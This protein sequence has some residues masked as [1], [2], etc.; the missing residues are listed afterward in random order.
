MKRK[1]VIL[2]DK[3]Q[4]SPNA[5]YLKFSFSNPQM[6]LGLATGKHIGIFAPMI[7]GKVHGKWNNGP[8]SEAGKSE[9][10][11]KF[12]PISCDEMDIGYFALVVKIYRPSPKFPDGG[13]MS[14]YLE[15]LRV[16]SSIEVA[17]PFGNH[18]YIGRGRLADNGNELIFKDCAMIAGGSG[19]TP[20]L[21]IV[22]AMLRDPSD[23]TRISLLYANST[24]DDILMRDHLDTL[25][26]TYPTRFRVWYTVSQDPK[27]SSKHYSFADWRYSTGR[28]TKQMMREHLPPPSSNNSIAIHCGPKAMMENVNRLLGELGYS[29]RRI[30]EY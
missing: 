4:I 14:R 19:I 13:R 9:I 1:R 5:Y 21:Q 8:D 30:V 10:T 23:Q 7:P 6:V 15:G 22:S 11:R 25:E 26:K 18:Q 17:G 16:G 3:I 2:A 12:T 27:Q 24:I 29:E 20:V 28:I